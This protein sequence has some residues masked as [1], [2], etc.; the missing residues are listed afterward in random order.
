MGVERELLI[1]FMDLTL[2]YP[3][4]CLFYE[5]AIANGVLANMSL[6]RG[7]FLPAG[8]QKSV[9]IHFHIDNAVF[10][11]D[12]LHDKSTIDTLNIAGFQRK[13]NLVSELRPLQID[14]SCRKQSVNKNNVNEKIVAKDPDLRLFQLPHGCASVPHSSDLLTLSQKDIYLSWILSRTVLHVL[15]SKECINANTYY[16]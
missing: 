12:A 16:K 2:S 14:H 4:Q 11:V 3:T 10:P 9:F 1:Y 7:F 15:Q 5:T 8:I 6:N 13:L